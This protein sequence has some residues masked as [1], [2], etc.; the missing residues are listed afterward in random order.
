MRI[1]VY[2]KGLLLLMCNLRSIISPLVAVVLE[3]LW[4]YEKVKK[5]QTFRI[6]ARTTSI[7]RMVKTK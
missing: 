4:L 1:I 6:N 5:V 2:G 7:E 3:R